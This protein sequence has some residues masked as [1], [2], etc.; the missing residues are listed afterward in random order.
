MALLCLLMLFN[1]CHPRQCDQIWPI[2]ATGK[3]LK[4]FDNLLRGLWVFGHS[5][6]PALTHSVCHW[7]NFH[8][9]RRP[10]IEK[11]T[12]LLV[13]LIRLF[14]LFETMVQF[15]N[16]IMKRN[17]TGNQTRDQCDQIFQYKKSINSWATFVR[18]FVS[19]TS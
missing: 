15:L 7:A 16:K 8:W 6:E 10:N 1:A 4:V 14:R 19:K 17:I 12:S 5:F 3:I 13:T 2:F 9:C 11:L 18:T